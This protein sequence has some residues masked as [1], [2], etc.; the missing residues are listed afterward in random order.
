MTGSTD[1]KSDSAQTSGSNNLSSFVTEIKQFQ[2]S[3]T[4]FLRQERLGTKLAISVLE[5]LSRFDK[6]KSDMTKSE[7]AGNLMFSLTNIFPSS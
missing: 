4:F 6:T 3:K 5:A 7:K 2:N 1:T